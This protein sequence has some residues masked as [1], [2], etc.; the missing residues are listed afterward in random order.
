[1][2]MGLIERM[3]GSITLTAKDI[4]GLP[5]YQRAAPRR[6]AICRKT[7]HLSRGLFPVKEISIG[8]SAADRKDRSKWDDNVDAA[9]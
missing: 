8:G 4:T 2:I 3:R 5:M 7:K 1:M 9:A 6:S